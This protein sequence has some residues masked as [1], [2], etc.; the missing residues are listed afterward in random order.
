ML[1]ADVLSLVML[2]IR[3]SDVD[4]GVQDVIGRGSKVHPLYARIVEA[5]AAKAIVVPAQPAKGLQVQ[6]SPP[7]PVAESQETQ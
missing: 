5:R 2:V 3:A 7:N 6:I 1:R 4:P